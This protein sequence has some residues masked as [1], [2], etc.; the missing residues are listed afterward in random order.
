MGEKDGQ[1]D[2]Q[3]WDLT[4]N[5]AESVVKCASAGM[6]LSCSAVFPLQVKT[7]KQRS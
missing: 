7:E 5:G 2:R 4:S 3:R 1:T 6:G